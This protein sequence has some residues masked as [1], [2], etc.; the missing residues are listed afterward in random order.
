MV[1]TR[2]DSFDGENLLDGGVPENG[3]IVKRNKV[4]MFVRKQPK[5][6]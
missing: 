2:T 5:T 3:V 6:S 1:L 4:F